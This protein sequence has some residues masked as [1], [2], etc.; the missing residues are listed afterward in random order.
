[1]SGGYSS[2]T[3]E[4]SSNSLFGSNTEGNG[5]SSGTSSIAVNPFYTKLNKKIA[6][7][8]AGAQAQGQNFLEGILNSAYNGNSTSGASNLVQ[9]MFGNQMAQA[10]SADTLGGDATARSGFREGAGLAQAQRDAV[11]IG[12]QAAG[13]LMGGP[14]PT[15]NLDFAASVAPHQASGTNFSNQDT[16][17]NQLTHTTQQ[18]DNWGAGITLCCFIFLEAYNGNLPWFVRASRD[19]FCTGPRVKGYRSMAQWLVPVMQTNRFV[20]WLVNLFMVKP[21]TRWGGWLFGEPGYR[22]GWTNFPLVAFWF[23]FWGRSGL[24]NQPDQKGGK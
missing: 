10:K 18:G 22:W 6:T 17:G 12:T 15:S 24:K 3:G 7:Q 13:A 9:N 1:M 14:S 21:L 20:R 11:G 19:M 2:S 5:G 8:N 16:S 23:L 4:G